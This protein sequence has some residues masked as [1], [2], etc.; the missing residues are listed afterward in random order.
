M[1]FFFSNFTLTCIF[2]AKTFVMHSCHS[3]IK[4]R[5]SLNFVARI[6]CVSLCC[7]ELSQYHLLTCV[8]HI[9]IQYWFLSLNHNV[10]LLTT[11]HSFFLPFSPFHYV[12]YAH[13][14]ICIRFHRNGKICSKDRWCTMSYVEKSRLANEI[15][16]EAKRRVKKWKKESVASK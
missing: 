15:E 16:S 8:T 9:H 6:P 1:Y 4:K 12:D 11:D 14:H 7:V 10:F 3:S 5:V 2:Q 13:R